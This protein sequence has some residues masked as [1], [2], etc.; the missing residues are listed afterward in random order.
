MKKQI[1]FHDAADVITSLEHSRVLLACGIFTPSNVKHPLFRAAFIEL[2]ILIRDLTQKS[3]IYAKEIDFK[4]DVNLKGA[5]TN[6]SMLIKYIRDAICHP[7]SDNH[8]ISGTD[9]KASFNVA[10][11]KSKLMS[12]GEL[13]FESR[14]E[15]DICFFYGDQ[16]IYLY[17]HLQRALNESEEQ[18]IE[19]IKNSDYRQLVR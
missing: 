3:W 14:Y 9:T 4:D 7:D 11:G 6:V 2:L 17:R 19:I 12:I 15:D 18:L 8:F 16:Q 13:S 10:F 1:G 5:V